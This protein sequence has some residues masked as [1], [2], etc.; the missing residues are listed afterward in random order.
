MDGRE[1]RIMAKRY[2]SSSSSLAK[3]KPCISACHLTA[4]DFSPPDY[5]LR[6]A[7]ER[8]LKVRFAVVIYSAIAVLAAGLGEGVAQ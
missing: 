5:P 6:V 8:G 7:A 1:G 2:L 4:D 3:D